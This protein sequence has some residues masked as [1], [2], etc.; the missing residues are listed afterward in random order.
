[1]SDL[2]VIIIFRLLPFWQP[3][4]GHILITKAL[5]KM[6]GFYDNMVQCIFRLLSFWQ[7]CQDHILSYKVLNGFVVIFQLLTFWQPCWGHILIT[8]ALKKC[9]VFMIW[10]N[11]HFGYPVGATNPKGSK[12]AFILYDNIIIQA[13]P[14]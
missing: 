4:W 11:T 1:M 8:K 5:K 9:R 10:C 13:V 6:Q 3:C 7:R 14:F 12:M 2:I